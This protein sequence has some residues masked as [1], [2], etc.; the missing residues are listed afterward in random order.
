MSRNLIQILRALEFAARKHRDQRRKGVAAEPY[1]NHLAEVTRLLAEATG[2]QDPVLLMA[3]LLH[4]TIEDTAT[5]HEE[6]AR[7]FGSEVADLVAEVTDDKSLP[8]KERKRRQIDRA[9]QA[10]PRA[11]LLKLADK[12]SNVRSIIQ[13]PPRRW[14]RRRKLQYLNW[15][16]QV[17]QHCRGS[18]PDL[19]KRFNAAVDA[20]RSAIEA[21]TSPERP[22]PDRS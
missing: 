21:E 16:Q 7:E 9:S 5:T 8:Q 6:L 14:N 19:E 22:H 17:V 2:G 1:V 20:A 13:S 10:S 3:G 11:R 15:A 12:T 18:S 4:D